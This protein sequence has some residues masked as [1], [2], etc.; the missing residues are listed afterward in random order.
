MLAGDDGVGDAP[1]EVELDAVP[2]EP[3]VLPDSDCTER[4]DDL[5]AVPCGTA[6]E[7]VNER[8]EYGAGVLGRGPDVNG[9]VPES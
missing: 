6:G 3:G 2:G 4:L 5:P 1:V 9:E 8:V 7:K